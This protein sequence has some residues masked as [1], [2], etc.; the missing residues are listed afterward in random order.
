MKKSQ[1]TNTFN[2]G[3]IMDLNP[4]VTPNDVLTN[5]LN[6]TLV[7]FNGNENVLQNDM[8]NGRVE[9]AYLPEGYVPLGTA[10]LGGIIYIVS[11][12]PLKNKCQIGSFP[13]PERNISSD[14][15]KHTNCTLSEKDFHWDATNGAYIYYLKKDL[16]SELIFNPGDKFIVYGDNILNNYSKFY[17]PDKYNTNK[18]PDITYSKNETNFDIAKLQTVKLDIG[19]ITDTGRLV[20]FSDLKQYYL[21]GSNNTYHIYQYNDEET[22]KPDLDE[23]RSLISQ[24]YNVF[25]SKVSGRL[26]LIAELVQCNTFDIEI[27][28]K[29]QTDDNA[30]KKYTPNVTFNFGGEYPFIPIQV[31]CSLSMFE[32]NIHYLSEEF[33]IEITDY[34]REQIDTNNQNYSISIND[35]LSQNKESVIKN[36]IDEIDFNKKDRNSGCILEYTFTPCMNWGPVSYLAVSGSIDL[37]KLGTGYIDLTTWKYYKQDSMNLTWGLEVYEEEG[38]DVTGVSMEFVRLLTNKTVEISTYS[39]DKKESYHGIFYG[40]LPLDQKYLK[41]TK[42]LIS[43]TLYLV[44]IIVTYSKIKE[45][46]STKT[47]SE[48]RVFYRWMYT[49]EV[50]N[51]Y[52]IST[53]DFIGLSLS[54]DPDFSINYTSKTTDRDQSTIYGVIRPTIEGKT[55]DEKLVLKDSKT[56]LSCIQTLRDSDVSCELSIGLKKTYNTFYLECQNNAFSLDINKDNLKNIANA[57]IKYTDRE[58]EN[59]DSYLSSTASIVNNLDAY[60]LTSSS[61]TNRS[62]EILGTDKKPFPTNAVHLI[63][64]NISPTFKDNVYTFQFQYESLQMVKA[65]CTKFESNLTYSG[66]LLPLAYD[67]ETFDLYNLQYSNGKWKPNVLGAFGFVER[68]GAKGYVWV[69]S[70]NSDNPNGSSMEVEHCNNVDLNWTTDAEIVQAEQKYG[71]SNTS[72]F[73]VH[74]WGQYGSHQTMNTSPTNLTYANTRNFTKSM[75]D[76]KGIDGCTRAQLFL[77]SNN[78]SCFYPIDYSYP[79]KACGY[80]DILIKNSILFND[81]AKILN[82]LYRYDDEGTNIACL[83]PQS[84]YYMDNCNYGLVLPISI[85]ST[86]ILQQCEVQLQLESDRVALNNIVNILKQIKIEGKTIIPEDYHEEKFENNLTYTLSKIDSTYEFNITNTDKTSGI[87]LRNYILDLQVTGQGICIMDYNGKDIIGNSTASYNKTRLYYI[88]KGTPVTVNVANNVPFKDII[89]TT[90]TTGNL[91]TQVQDDNLELG[92]E[93]LNNRFQLNDEGLLILKDPPASEYEMVRDVKNRTTQDEGAVR[94]FQKARLLN[95]YKYYS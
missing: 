12:N 94:G 81:F 22:I 28:H 42:P 36:R 70:A 72:V 19:T 20:K 41:L 32:K 5:C 80:F 1:A 83:V 58:D 78:D 79:S 49:N 68:S 11:Y 73:A 14:E 39:I 17:N 88:I 55:D 10:E 21:P 34:I 24:P 64:S 6:G 25:N 66:R 69:G 26:V 59:Q 60:K 85:K 71:W 93:N 13:S 61:G 52:Y 31:K 15:I 77:K 89:W 50:F 44:K 29:F 51:S 30:K 40:I 82:N 53:T 65:Y 23:Y 54:L 48:Q 45:E 18:D 35:I 16:D 84:I 63:T 67:E 3:M 75:E 86:D 90:D 46:I 74:F 37:D 92:R 9:T 57:T 38:Y 91:I 27:S 4:L 2:K 7:T 47:T 95:K 87:S 33:Y 8:G 76:N 62:N 43:N 56:S